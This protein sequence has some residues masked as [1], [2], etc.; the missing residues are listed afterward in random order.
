[1][2]CSKCDSR[3]SSGLDRLKQSIDTLRAGDM[4]PDVASFKVMAE[5][6]ARRWTLVESNGTWDKYRFI[7][8]SQF[9]YSDVSFI[10]VDKHGRVL[11]VWRGPG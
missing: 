4:L 2:V 10:T 1:M 7:F 5:E 3:Q 9:S 6:L 8:W 11:A